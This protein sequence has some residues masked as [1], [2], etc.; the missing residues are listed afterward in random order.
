MRPDLADAAAAVLDANWL[1]HSTLP[2]PR[3]YPHQWSWDSAFVAIGNAQ[4]AP[5]RSRLELETLFEAQWTNGLVPHIVFNP[6][7][8]AYFP[9]P[10]TWRTDV[11]PHAPRDRATSGIVQP[12]VHATAVWRVHSIAPDR[13]WLARMLPRL[14]AW[15]DYLYRERDPEEDGLVAIR[16]PWESGMDDSPA[17]DAPLA[18]IELAPGEVPPYPR[19]DLTMARADERPTAQA[20]DHYVHLVELFKRH[21]YDEREIRAR[22]RFVVE[23]PCFN[24][25]LAAAGD[26]LASIAEELGEDGSGF[27]ERAARTRDQVN[28]RLWND[29][30]HA[31]VPFD[32]VARRQV[33]APVAGGF[34]PLF[35]RIPSAGRAQL[36]CRQLDSAHFWPHGGEG[37]PVPTCDRV[38]PGF[39]P[40]RYWRGPAWVNVNW[41]VLCGLRHYGFD[42]YADAL[43]DATLEL[44]ANAGFTEY[45]HP[46]TGEG[47]GAGGFSWSAALTLDLLR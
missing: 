38:H 23:D 31:Y 28:R 33:L 39:V 1:G 19:K 24:A 18:A 7:S 11:S 43:R 16:H 20:Y 47:L 35:A 4:R 34:V 29:A 40:T 42:A 12:P 45:F 22:S 15:H 13:D 37:W 17:W 27:R 8:E 32:R 36:M 10:E 25:L 30:L 14:A 26:D 44:V 46:L 2:S 6:E 41:L 3:L 5:E 21:R 9:G